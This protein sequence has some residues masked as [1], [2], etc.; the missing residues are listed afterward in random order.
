MAGKKLGSVLAVLA[1]ALVAAAGVSALSRP[2]V[3]SLLVVGEQFTPIGLSE[4]A[5]PKAGDGFALVGGLYKWAGRT[6][7]QRVG[8]SEVFCTFT[9][10][11]PTASG[12]PAYCTASAFLPAGE[13]L[14]A[15]FVRLPEGPV[16]VAV[17]VVGGT[18][19]YS[20]ARG[21]A[22]FRDIGPQTAG[23]TSLVLH[24][25]P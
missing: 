1:L 5:P 7:G 8:R 2:Q 9:T 20:N 13:V 24:L 15:G 10:G 21:W 12:A 16:N 25:V 23:H 14:L 17:A 3:I 22:S 4:N 18:G 11:Q 6:R 19:G